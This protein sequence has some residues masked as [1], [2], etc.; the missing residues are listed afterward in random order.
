MVMLTKDTL[1]DEEKLIKRTSGSPDYMDRESRK[2]LIKTLNKLA[3][4][5]KLDY[6]FLSNEL[7]SY[8]PGVPENPDISDL[9]EINKTYALAQS[10]FSRVSNISLQSIGDLNMWSGLLE[11]TALYVEDRKNS[12]LLTEEALK[13]PNAGTQKAYVQTKLRKLLLFLNEVKIQYNTS[14]AFS[15]Q[16][17]SKKKD[18]SSI[19]TT[20][21]RQVKV[22]SL[23][24]SLT[25]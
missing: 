13:L 15:K 11:V 12:M 19:L 24:Q 10:Y 23:E 4:R 2:D 22:L 14:L 18:L 20:L 8:T 5:N 21:S 16:V 6:G 9:S 7:D 1:S 25:R 3:H 17:D